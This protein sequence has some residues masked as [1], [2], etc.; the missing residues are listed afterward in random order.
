MTKEEI[1]EL[2]KDSPD[3]QTYINL[4]CRTGRY[5]PKEVLELKIAEEVAEAYKGVK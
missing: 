5:T 4:F 1:K 3:F 2:Y